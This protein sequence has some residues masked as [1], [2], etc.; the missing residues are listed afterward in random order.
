MLESAAFSKDPDRHQALWMLHAAG[1]FSEAV[2]LRALRS[3]DPLLQTW[4]I[5]FATDDNMVTPS[6]VHEFLR[7]ASEPSTKP[8]PLQQLICSVKRMEERNSLVILH[9]MMVR[10]DLA[11]DPF[12]PLLTWWALEAQVDRHPEIVHWF[13]RSEIWKS[14][15]VLES[16]VERLSRRWAAG[17]Q[18]QLE[19]SAKLFEHAPT[20]QARH[21]V[22]AGIEAAFAGKSP[23]VVPKPLE[24]IAKTLWNGGSADAGTAA[25]LARL[26]F[27]PAQARI[28]RTLTD[29]KM[30]MAD[31]V[32]A[33]SLVGELAFP[34][35][36]T[37]LLD[38]LARDDEKHLHAEVLRALRRYNDPRIG[39]VILAR[40][41][42]SK[43][44][45]RQRC[46]QA[47]ASKP[48]QA[49]LLLDAVLEK[50]I[51]PEEVSTDLL[52]GML[53]FNNPK[54]SATIEQHW[55]KIKPPSPGEKTARVHGIKV[56]LKLA[57]GNAER[58]KELF[59]KTC[60]NC[61][62]LF[63]EGAKIGPDLT[64]Q[65]RGNLDFLLTSIVDPNAVIRREFMSQ[66]LVLTDG[67]VIHGLVAE[68][69]ESRV[70]VIDSKAEKRIVPRSDIEEIKPSSIS[71]MPEKLL[72]SL[73][74]QQVR[75]LISY[76]QT[77]PATGPR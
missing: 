62:T 7:L 3:G 65:D 4:A 58:G 70:V 66:T 6:L 63:G 74:A 75:D 9:R 12:Q 11:D 38:L 33:A 51:R 64:G 50:S 2:A 61:H 40:L 35:G 16:I 48:S 53:A 36:L 14:R 43:D 69:T 76:L 34:D 71:V 5:R 28:L 23:T 29:Q 54:W 17:T 1:G 46:I 21:K 8:R 41:K 13:D 39:P 42:K 73:D 72:D 44:S 57:R 45:L 67:Q 22:L 18:S 25:L 37:P 26:G 47:L 31:R 52:A 32:H 60:A 15:M 20:D 19:F 10:D 59:K 24:S 27:R 55:G 56:S 68:A 77:K 30:P 49:G